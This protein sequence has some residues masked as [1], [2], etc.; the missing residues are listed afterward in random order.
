MVEASKFT[1]RQM[2]EAAERHFTIE[3][4]AAADTLVCE[5]IS[6]D[7][8]GVTFVPRGSYPARDPQS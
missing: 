3:H 2:R 5:A 4:L 1:E 6:H 7:G 8:R